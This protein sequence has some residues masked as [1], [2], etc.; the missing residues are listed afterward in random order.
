VLRE[1]VVGL[2]DVLQAHRNSQ[3]ASL[4]AERPAGT[5]PLRSASAS[6]D[7]TLLELLES[8]GRIYGGA[9]DTLREVLRD[10]KDH[11]QATATALPE[12]VRAVVGQ[13]DPQK[14]LDQIKNGRASELSPGEDPRPRYWE[15]FAELHRVLTQNLDKELP[16]SFREEFARSYLEARNQLEKDR[17]R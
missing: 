12:G 8:H 7:K 14:V 13:L 11:E 4:V 15:H 10:I 5:N 1:V 3:Q 16:H 17:K 2:R 6:V 9:V